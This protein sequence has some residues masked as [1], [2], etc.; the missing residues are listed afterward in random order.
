MVVLSW[1]SWCAQLGLA[2]A[3][4]AGTIGARGDRA[5][6]QSKITPDA[7][8]GGERSVVTPNVTIK[9]LPSDKIDG[10]AT[11]GSNLFHS[12]SEFNVGGGRGVYFSNPAGIVNIFSRVTGNIRS[13][14][15]GTLGV[16]GGNA[17]LFFIN[18]NGIIFGP[19]ARLDVGG[20]FLASTA[21]AIQFGNQG[22]FSASNP[23]APPLLTINPDALL[24]LNQIPGTSIQNNSVALDLS[25]TSAGLHVPDGQSL[26]LVGGNIIM[27]GGILNASGGRV[28][29]GGLAGSGTVGLN[30]NGNNLSLSFPDAV[31]RADV[32]LNNGAAVDVKAGGGGS[33]AVNARN[34]DV[35]GGSNLSAGIR[36]GLGAVG[37]QAG[38]I[39]LN[40]TGATQV[41]KSYI[42]NNFGSRATGKSGGNINITTGSLYV[43]NFAQL[44]ASTDGTGDAGAVT[45]NAQD[46]VSFDSAYTFNIVA[47][48][49]VGNS[50]GINI[51][52]GSLFLANGA[53][54]QTLVAGSDNQLPAGRGN[55]GDINITA[56]DMVS[57][58]REKPEGFVSAVFSSLGQGGEGKGGDI[59][60]K[61]GSLSLTDGAQV[62]TGAY[63]KGDAGN[64]TIKASDTVSLNNGTVFSNVTGKGNGGSID[65]T[66]PSLSLIQNSALKTA[67]ET[68]GQGKA[69]SINIHVQGSV[70]MDGEVQDRL[71]AIASYIRPGSKNTGGAESQGGDIII[72]AGSLSL[73]RAA[74]I[75]TGV[76]DNENRAMAQGNGGNISINLRDALSLNQSFIASQVFSNGSGHAGNIDI[77]A[78]SVSTN[79]SVISASTA[80]MGNAGKVSVKAVGGAISLTN[81]DIS[82]E[83][84]GMGDA[85]GIKITARSLS[86]TNGAQLNAVTSGKGKAGDIVI[87]AT[88][89]VSVSGTNTTLTPRDLF[90]SLAPEFTTAPDFKVGNPGAFSGLTV[91][92]TGSGNAGNID[93]NAGSLSLTDG[94]Q[95]VASTSGK[96]D[97]GSVRITATGPV[98]F[99]KSYAFS[100]VEAGGEGKGGNIDIKA[101]SLSLTD[102]V[103]LQ[104]QTS[105]KGDAGSVRITATG[106]VSFKNNSY[107]F[108]TVE[109]GAVG[110]GGDIDIK[111]GSLSLTEGAQLVAST[112][113]KG[114]SGS[115][116]IT[117]TGPVSFNNSSAFSSVEA[118]GEG[119]GGDIDIKAGS[120]SLTDGAQVN[121][122]A[123]GKGDAGN[124]TI[125]ASDTV[126]LNNGTVFS[127]VTGKGNGGSIDITAPSLSLIQNSALKTA[128]ETGGQGKAGS[129]NIHVQGSVLMDGEVQDR[130]P[131]IASYIRPGSKNTGGAESQGGDIII[132]AGSLSLRRAAEIGTGVGDNENRAMAQGNGG[133]ISINLRDALSLN[134]SFIASQVFSNGSGHAGNIDIQA[135][136]VSTNQSVISASTAGMGNA[137]K[138]SVKAVGGAISLTN[139]DISTETTGM[140]DAQGIKITARSLSL[141]NGAQLNAVTSGKGKA[142]D[143]VID[144]TDTVSVSG[145]N[146]T[147]TPRDLFKSLAP[148]FT[149]AP[150]FK[151]GNLGAFSGLTVSST[152]S[153]NA[154]NLQVQARQI[155]L[156]NQ[157]TLTSDDSSGGNGGNIS[158]SAS[159]LLLLRHGSLISTSAGTAQRGGD[160]GK[161]DINAQFI[162]AVP[163]ED[164]DIRANAFKGKGGTIDIKTSGVFGFQINPP[165]DTPLSDITASSEVGPQGIVTI[166]TPEV[167]PASGLFVLPVQVVDASRQI[168][169]S[170]CP[171]GDGIT[172]NQFIVTGRGGLPPSPDDILSGDVVWSDTRLQ[173]FTASGH[174]Q[175]RVSAKPRSHPAAVAIVPA[176]GWVFN[177]KGEVT[178]I[179]S[180]N[181]TPESFGSNGVSCHVSSK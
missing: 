181:A 136:S 14:I 167:N 78:G 172:G 100:T 28:E 73:R 57:F 93:I 74:E 117:A 7:T 137:G 71:P 128:V 98:S 175:Q 108:S 140:G 34:I 40:A 173:G 121:T 150:D 126:S 55:A 94:A 143:I 37:S 156:D 47:T 151:V 86:L 122:G 90:K 4:V 155:R 60:I 119:K 35:L 48:G 158:L 26:L 102:G 88:D 69:G 92:S 110:K 111:A 84:T 97:A 131:A 25:A 31:V 33:I 101:G 169:A 180:P 82:T 141:T 5:Y 76:G 114:D 19:N 77:Q 18:P 21:N 132:K 72:K 124:V 1:W 79:Q 104:A 70:L 105:G 53:Q 85:Q 64:V 127:N 116:R 68:G 41:V 3:L 135:G 163:Q 13:E 112:R 62:N 8:L 51:N 91:S 63:G 29:L 59:D 96:G 154:G 87:D 149:T 144:A 147:F 130:L 133:N 16:T 58:Y 115:V 138:V 120:L 161:V 153:G 106:L 80:G 166:N 134:Q 123:Y 89:T 50:G 113:G 54:L 148:E 118:G 171:A 177:N 142:G 107:A 43:K 24:Y 32:S 9:G 6:A 17:N 10:G 81:S 22:K 125:K 56:R 11:R 61:A 164:S 2:S 75:G 44:N 52:T 160:G 146:T 157:G 162:V 179:A 42:N 46:T 66:A 145:T 129:I 45:I 20:S 15:L 176:T 36:S 168:V 83:T 139:S 39:T 67:V 159:D 65:I 23:D 152:G 99:N 95:L 38:D 12:F 49:A 27:D 109:A 174:P 30:V 178:L 170:G 103:Q 165:Q